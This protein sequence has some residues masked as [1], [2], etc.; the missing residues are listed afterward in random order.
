MLSGSTI[1][2][3][4]WVGWLGG[5]VA[6]WLSGCLNTDYKASLSPAELHCCWNWAELGNLQVGLKISFLGFLHLMSS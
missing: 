1:L 5:L 6:G 2:G 3:G 4:W